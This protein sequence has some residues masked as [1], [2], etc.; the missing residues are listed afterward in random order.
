MVIYRNDK[1]KIWKISILALILGLLVCFELKLLDYEANTYKASFYA[2]PVE[3]FE[4][5]GVH[6]MV[7]TTRAIGYLT[8]REQII[9]GYEH[10]DIEL[11]DLYELDSFTN[12]YDK[13]KIID[14]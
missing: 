10:E 5:S 12:R 13:R 2:D 7:V 3:L 1:A 4:E 8:D 9:K 6:M 11:I 14:C